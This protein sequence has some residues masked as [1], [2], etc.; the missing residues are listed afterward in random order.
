MLLILTILLASAAGVS[1]AGSL[2][3]YRLL[4]LGGAVVK[5]GGPSLGEGARVSYAIVSRPMSFDGARNCAELAPIEGLL[6]ESDVGRSV[7]EAE[8]ARAFD[9]WSRAANVTFERTDEATA[10]ILIGAQGVPMGRAFTNVAF[11][12]PPVAG[13]PGAIV[14]SVICLNPQEPWK[15]GFDGD[16]DK[17]DLRYTLMHEIGH[18]LGLDHPGV[19]GVL[20]DFRYLETFSA[21]QDGDRAGI[22]SLYGPKL[23]D[24]A[25]AP[26][27]VSAPVIPGMRLNAAERALGGVDPD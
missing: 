1:A 15:I 17:Y 25:R 11:A 10:N 27:E 13:A 22:A 23:E 20:M 8:L 2:A 7:F 3:D 4:V 24:T 19:P 26:S 18:A 16:L 14:G 9:E 21:L 12:P 6:R 5:W